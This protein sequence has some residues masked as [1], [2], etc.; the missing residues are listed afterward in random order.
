MAAET[1]QQNIL[2]EYPS[3]FGN[4]GPGRG[5]W[6]GA[7]AVPEYDSDPRPVPVPGQAVPHRAAGRRLLKASSLSLEGHGWPVNPTLAW[8]RL[9][10]IFS[11]PFKEPRP[12]T[13]ALAQA[14]GNAKLFRWAVSV[15]LGAGLTL[16]SEKKN[17]AVDFPN[18]SPKSHAESQANLYRPL[19]L[20][21]FFSLTVYRR[22]AA[23]AASES[24][25]CRNAGKHL[26]FRVPFSTVTV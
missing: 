11:F 3:K 17:H 9:Q 26:Y 4:G 7:Q 21:K 8:Y 2:C 5:P 13:R 22:V 10:Q 20:I 25:L 19:F 1:Y 14:A 24:G 6:P 18:P 12:T 16:R 23:G 15:G